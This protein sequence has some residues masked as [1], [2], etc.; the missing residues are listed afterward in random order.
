MQKK[1]KRR[2][3]RK[4]RKK[5]EQP[6]A[7]GNLNIQIQ[8]HGGWSEE[9]QM[10]RKDK[11]TQISKKYEES[12]NQERHKKEQQ[13]WQ[14]QKKKWNKGWK[15]H[16][17]WLTSRELRSLCSPALSSSTVWYVNPS[18]SAN[19]WAASSTL[20]IPGEH[21]NT[22]QMPTSHFNALALWHM[23]FPMHHHN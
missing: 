14:K 3:T 8:L 17:T 16:Q 4:K 23:A 21:T 11:N 1:E 2:E 18:L 10:K 6:N 20:G 13:K 19:C 15:R 9:E 12:Q 22:M 7:Q 5:E